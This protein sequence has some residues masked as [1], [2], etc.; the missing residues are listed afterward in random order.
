MLAVCHAVNIAMRL[1]RK[2]VYDPTV[3]RFKGD[4]EANSFVQREQ[5]KGY[6]IAV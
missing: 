5:R 3:D 1:N 2:L 4:E 6:E